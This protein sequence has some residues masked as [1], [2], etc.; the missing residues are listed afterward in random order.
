MK[1]NIRSL[2]ILLGVLVVVGGVAAV[3]LLNPPAQEATTSSAAPASSAASEKVM[4]RQE[5]EVT[6]VKVEN[7]LGSYELIPV[8]QKTET[9]SAPASSTSSEAAAP[10][11]NFTVKGLESY[12]VDAGVATAAARS[13]LS[14]SASKNL[15]TPESL[16]AYG[17]TGNGQAKVTL[18]YQDGKTDTLVMGIDAGESAGKYLLKDGTVYICSGVSSQLLENSLSY[19]KKDIYTV[20]DRIEETVDSAGSA[21][22][23]VGA[24][25]LQ[26]ATISGPNLPKPAV[27]QYDQNSFSGYAMTSPVVAEAGSSSSF[28]TVLSSLKTL[29]AD[30]VAAVGV[31]EEDLETYGLSQP[32]AQISYTLNSEDHS[33]QVSAPD[34][35]GMCHVRAD[36]GDVI[37][38]ME[39]SKLQPWTELSVMDLRS[40]YILLPNIMEVSKLTLTTGGQTTEDGNVYQVTRTLNEEKS[41]EETPSYDLT[42]AKNDGSAIEYTNYQSFYK[43]LIALAVLSTDEVVYES[44]PVLTVTYEYFDGKEADVISLYP[45]AGQDRYM[46][47]LNGADSGLVRKASVDELIAHIETLNANQPVA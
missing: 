39:K 2:L 25:L 18:S 45:V 9:S 33:L 8:E 21:T 29:T 27:L 16:E 20:A 28:E 24:D 34:A 40:G 14:V 43:K 12:P 36:E 32:Y 23:G 1:K 7:A 37:Y 41:T 10:T 17:L 5:S 30:S 3:L 22:E 44:Q 4:D 11:V 38:L 35:Q 19:M 47:L 46:A 13:V 6:A 31:T 15:G 42:I 26:Q